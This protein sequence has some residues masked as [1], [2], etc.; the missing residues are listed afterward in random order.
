MT[1]V[2][3]PTKDYLIFDGL[4]TLTLTQATGAP[5]TVQ[6]VNR[7]P[8]TFKAMQFLMGMGIE[9]IGVQFHASAL[10]MHGRV[11]KRGDKLTDSN[12]ASFIV[13]SAVY[14]QI[15]NDYDV[16]ATQTRG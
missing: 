11:L 12:G 10:E 5:V 3:D 14:Q 16:I 6:Y 13:Q 9:P 4:E 1:I 15:T 7:G 2:F 8:L